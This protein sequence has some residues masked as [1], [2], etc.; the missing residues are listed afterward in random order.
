MEKHKY[1]IGDKIKW[2]ND[3]FP[4]VLCKKT[5]MEDNKTYE[6]EVKSRKVVGRV[7]KIIKIRELSNKY[8][9]VP[10][11]EYEIETGD[12]AK[13]LIKFADKSPNWNHKILHAY[14]SE[15]EKINII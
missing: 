4:Q 15:I 2:V 8:N 14:E 1:K 9:D 13:Y 5:V 6:Y 7:G 10:L 12:I 3:K 11:C